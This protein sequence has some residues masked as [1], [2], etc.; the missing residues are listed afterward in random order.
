ME[1]GIGDAIAHQ[2]K[3]NLFAS[4]AA[5]ALARMSAE[6][7]RREAARRKAQEADDADTKKVISDSDI[8][9]KNTTWHKMYASAA[10]REMADFANDYIKHKVENPNDPAKG[11]YAVTRL[12]EL[13]ARMNR[14]KQS[15]DA[16]KDFE[17]G[18]HEGKYYADPELFKKIYETDFSKKLYRDDNGRV[19]SGDWGGLKPDERYGAMIDANGDFISNPVKK[20]DFQK[21]INGRMNDANYWTSTGISTKPRKGVPNAYDEVQDFQED[22]TQRE[23]FV[24]EMTSN[25][26]AVRAWQIENKDRLDEA[27]KRNPA[28][29]N[30]RNYSDFVQEQMAGD[31][32]LKASGRKQTSKISHFAAPKAP[33][34][35]KE[36]KTLSLDSTLD[37]LS[38]YMT[39]SDQEIVA[40]PVAVA[41]EEAAANLEDKIAE[42]KKDSNFDKDKI[43]GMEA[44]LKELQDK[45]ARTK[46]VKDETKYNFPVTLKSEGASTVVNN[47]DDVVDLSTGKK[48]SGVNQFKF[49]PRLIKLRK[50]KGQWKPF[51]YGES[52]DKI[53]A[54]DKSGNTI[55]DKTASATIAVPLDKVEGFLNKN[56]TPTSWTKEAIQR[57]GG[58]AKAAESTP[59]KA[60]EKLYT[61]EELKAMSPQYTD[62]IIDAA[63][64]AGK[65]KLK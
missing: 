27:R 50:V 58:S 22:P 62:E 51:V 20:F 11:A 30:D 23:S 25:P 5:G 4:Q 19:V 24:D 35:P 43:P 60:E 55:S 6:E 42:A 45:I 26:D 39:E 7:S 28:L 34:P 2:D 41:R 47:N 64:A 38:K 49:I 29:N 48:L 65:I 14:L 57:A 56:G 40:N 9:S 12:Q 36:S 17:K 61:R 18:V 52:T 13:S 21:T 53:A 54:S 44:S 32:R 8:Y 16:F 31:I 63:V 15:N 3:P 33:A 59:A 46:D 1:A 10:Q 37:D